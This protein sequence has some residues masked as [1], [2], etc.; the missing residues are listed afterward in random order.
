M[1]EVRETYIVAEIGV[2]HNGSFGVAKDLVYKAKS[3]GANAVKFQTFKAESL[4]STSVSL[5]DYQ[6][7]N[8]GRVQKQVDMLKSLELSYDD[9]KQLYKYCCD[10]NIDFISSPFDVSS[11]ELLLNLGLRVIKV[12]SG[13][14]L[15]L[16]LLWFLANAKADIILSTGMAN[17]G[18]V[19]LA[20]GTIDHAL[21]YSSPPS[22]LKEI[23][24]CRSK[25]RNESEIFR[26]VTLLHCN[27][28]Y[29]TSSE[30]VNLRAIET[31]RKSFGLQVGFSDHSEGDLACLGAVMLNARIIEKHLTLNKEMTGPDHLVSLEPEEFKSLCKKIRVLEKMQGDGLKIPFEEELRTK[32]VV[33]RK[34]VTSRAVAKGE[35]WTKDN[36]TS[37]RSEKGVEAKFY[38]DILQTPAQKEYLPFEELE[39]SEGNNGF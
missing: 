16:E 4:A 35:L 12:G 25:L 29:P 30:Q 34:L 1:I 33:G 38:W 13:E 9:F 11:A 19:E 20:L 6:I 32:K 3:A 10:L 8:T 39:K 15:N 26:K 22:S 14:L 21:N 5:A 24:D 27:S 7:K 18:D 28:S 36:L 17:L 31:L 23:F 2:N 37:L